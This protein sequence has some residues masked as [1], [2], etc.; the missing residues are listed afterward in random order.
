MQ[1]TADLND[2][3]CAPCAN[4]AGGGSK[5]R[6]W[7]SLLESDDG[8][9]PDFERLDRSGLGALH[10]AIDRG[11]TSLFRQALEAGAPIDQ[12][13]AHCKLSPLHYAASAINE[14]FLVSLLEKG[15]FID[16]RDR[17]RQTP[18]HYAAEVG[19]AAHATRLIEGGCCPKPLDR[20]KRSP[21]DVAFQHGRIQMIEYLVE[22]PDAKHR[23]WSDRLSFAVDR[24]QPEVVRWLLDRGA[25]PETNRDPYGRTILELSQKP[26]RA[27]DY[28]LDGC[29][30]EQIK[31]LSDN[32]AQVREMIEAALSNR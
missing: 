4:T 25:N 22:I 11:D 28:R 10:W 24:G 9:E 23:R 32:H 3:R 16:A 5:F 27:K 6:Y 2:G 1:I 8:R 29:T 17:D 31:L 12:Q 18:L 14:F 19:Y 26:F 7:K 21:L 15:A 30:E 20:Y 13:T